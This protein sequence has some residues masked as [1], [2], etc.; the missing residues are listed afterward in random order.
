[1][2][3]DVLEIIEAAYAESA[4]PDAWLKQALA[5]IQP[6]LDRGTG[7]L[8]HRF[9][10]RPGEFWRGATRG[11][12][13]DEALIPSLDVMLTA[14]RGQTNEGEMLAFLRRVYPRA[15]VVS[16]VNRLIGK[17]WSADFAP[18]LETMPADARA[19]LVASPD[20]LGVIAGDPS[21]EGC[22]FFARG[23]GAR[24]PHQTEALWRCI[25]SHLVT[26]YRLARRSPAEPEAV[27]SPSGK[28]LHLRT[29]LGREDAEPLT[30]ATR[31]I[32]QA[33]G[34]LRRTDPE[35]ALTLWR[36][37][38]EGRWSLVDHFDHDGRRYVFAKRNAPDV[39]PWD[40]LTDRE[41]QVVA[42]VAQGQTHKIIAYQ[43]GLSPSA[44]G[45]SL[46]RARTKLGARSRL[47]L[48][49]AYLAAEERTDA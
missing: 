15:P 44:V 27:L 23:E 43:L 4:D 19:K 14:R 30:E 22:I 49:A 10:H 37:L 45:E 42:F 46:L 35:R 38:V 25:A 32:D 36:G 20:A 28:V 2:A 11:I 41:S 48:V 24:L 34:R 39:R 5:V 8:A 17:A 31:A 9:A 26:G 1:M 33:R 7:V 29:D 13:A 16:W 6:H 21:G 18:A 3:R 40:T 12:G 47:E